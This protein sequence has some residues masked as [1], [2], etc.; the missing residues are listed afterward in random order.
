MR[1]CGAIFLVSLLSCEDPTVRKNS[2]TANFR[3]LSIE[4][5]CRSTAGH[6]S[7][8][9]GVSEFAWEPWPLCKFTV[10]TGGEMM[11]K[12]LIGL[13]VVPFLSTAALAQ[14]PTPLS[15]SQMDSVTAGF[16]F[17]EEDVGNTSWTQ[18]RVWQAF[19]M[20]GGN[21]IE[22]SRCYIAINSPALSIGSA[23]GPF[24]D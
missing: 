17:Q 21:D 18:V 6:L 19:Q 20:V 15:E 3:T 24:P 22:C 5:R 2:F 9:A 4:K 13:A 23:F 16:A 12:L 7:K 11:R 1:R 14:Q 8:L 10:G